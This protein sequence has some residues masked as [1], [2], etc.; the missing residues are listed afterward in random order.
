MLSRN[1][2]MARQESLYASIALVLVSSVPLSAPSHAQVEPDV[3]AFAGRTGTL[4]DLCALVAQTFEDGMSSMHRCELT[5]GVLPGFRILEAEGSSI[6][7]EHYMLVDVRGPELR[8]VATLESLDT[9]G[10][11]YHYEEFRLDRVERRSMGGRSLVVLTTTRRTTDFDPGELAEYDDRR[12]RVTFC[13]DADRRLRSL[14]C[15]ARFTV[16]RVGAHWALRERN[17]RDWPV[18]AYRAES[19][20]ARASFALLRDGRVRL[21]RR[22]D[23]WPDEDGALGSEDTVMLS[24]F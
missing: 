13:I 15:V 14:R 16:R 12:T 19:W 11:F 2:D 1:A 3:D 18:R 7:L 17:D 23:D 4:A 20:K 21:R 5:R 22:G 24:L 8:V 9:P 6:E 10:M